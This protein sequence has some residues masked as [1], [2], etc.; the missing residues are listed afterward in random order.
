MNW[1]ALLGTGER[2]FEKIHIKMP[3][4]GSD[5]KKLIHII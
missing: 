1:R 4:R 5:Y 3:G 2:Y